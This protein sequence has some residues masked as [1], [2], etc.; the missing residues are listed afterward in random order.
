MVDETIALTAAAW[1]QQFLDATDDR[2]LAVADHVLNQAV[3]AALC[4]QM[5]H[6]AELAEIRRSLDAITN[7]FELVLSLTG[8][9]KVSRIHVMD[10]DGV[11]SIQCVPDENDGYTIQALPKT[12]RIL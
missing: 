12:E 8:P 11:L 9:V 1:R 5:D 7:A 2:Q 6:E 10:F 4:F 3:V